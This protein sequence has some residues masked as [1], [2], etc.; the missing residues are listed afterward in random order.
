MNPLDDL[1]G[2]FQR[3]LDSDLSRVELLTNALETSTEA[4]KELLLNDSLTVGQRK[5]IGALIAQNERAL[6]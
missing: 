6:S 2:F 5:I 3:D 4:L 1:E